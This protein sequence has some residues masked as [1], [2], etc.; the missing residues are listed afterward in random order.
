MKIKIRD[1]LRGI[2]D[3]LFEHGQIRSFR[4]AFR[5]LAKRW[6][7][8]DRKKVIGGKSDCIHPVMSGFKFDGGKPYQV[9]Q[10]CFGKIF[11]RTKEQKQVLETYTN[12]TKISREPQ[13]R[14]DA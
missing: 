8:S 4:R 2:I 14:E 13:L 5:S 9:C 6:H 3:S 12:I 7:L 11:E 1:I 10:E